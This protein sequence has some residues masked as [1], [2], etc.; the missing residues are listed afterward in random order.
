MAYTKSRTAENEPMSDSSFK[1]A[2]LRTKYATDYMLFTRNLLKVYAKNSSVNRE[3]KATQ[4]LIQ[5][6]VFLLDVAAGKRGRPATEEEM[7]NLYESAASVDAQMQFF[8]KMYGESKRFKKTVDEIAQ[9]TGLTLDHLKTVS[10]E[11]EKEMREIAPEKE[12]PLDFVKRTA[13][14]VAAFGSQFRRDFINQALGPFAPI[15][16]MAW[17]AFTG[18]RKMQR[19]AKTK[20]ERGRY[21][22]NFGPSGMDIG[23]EAA[24]GV[25]GK[26]SRGAGVGDIFGDV[27][28]GGAESFRDFFG[29]KAYDTK[30]TKEVVDHLR[31]MSRANKGTG[32]S[33][34]GEVLSF[35]GIALTELMAF[36]AP[37]G[38]IL[39]AGAGVLGAGLA[40][41]GVGT[42]MNKT[43]IG[44][45]SLAS[46][47]P[48]G[49]IA[50]T[51]GYLS[52]GG[53][54][55]E[56][57]AYG[58]SGGTST[59]LFP[60]AKSGMKKAEDLG[61][62]G[63]QQDTSWVQD[64]VSGFNTAAGNIGKTVSGAMSTIVLPKET[65]TSPYKAADPLIDK[66]NRNDES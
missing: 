8:A 22:S 5:K 26:R 41:V 21:W 20:A 43:K 12:S 51:A 61:L 66:L 40:G 42:L 31:E 7:K 50:N 52:G 35:L 2:T 30:W 55:K 25:M 19:T 15:G 32:G 65:K 13:P 64:L 63:G 4:M 53:G 49:M 6:T 16:Q 24:E 56:S 17:G 28:S 39:L 46:L 10:G 48:I 47:T 29:N 11:M 33:S 9:N 60:S 37:I 45:R 23:G 14:G 34:L 58:L 59:S 57:I 62:G 38:R 27:R 3:I 18:L 1:L 54:I 36:L 44:G